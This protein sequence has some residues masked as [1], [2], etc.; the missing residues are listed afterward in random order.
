[1][2]TERES[3]T[4]PPPPALARSITYD[5]ES[6]DYLMRLG[7]EPIGYAR[8]YHQ[9]EITLDALAAEVLHHQHAALL[10]TLHTLDRMS[11]DLPAFRDARAR[12]LLGVEIGVAADG[13]V[14]QIDGL[15]VQP[16]PARI[17]WPWRCPCEQARC[18]HAALAEA[19]VMVQAE[20]DGA[21]VVAIVVREG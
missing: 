16:D 5:R 12:L 2:A 13:A 15:L 11:G 6:R 8:T 10:D 7:G 18:W 4:T 1:M 19:L 3:T 17:G 21:A 20:S 14:Y 9:A